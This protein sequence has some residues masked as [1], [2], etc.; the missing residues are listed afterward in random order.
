MRHRQGHLVR[1]ARLTRGAC[2]LAVAG[3]SL[4]A[5]CSLE[6]QKPTEIPPPVTPTDVREAHRVAN[7]LAVYRRDD[8]LI[9]TTRRSCSSG[10]APNLY[11]RVCGP[12]LRPL[13]A[14]QLTHLRESLDGL[15][16]RVGPDCAG[17][18]RRVA[19]V[20]SGRA[21]APLAVAARSC[22]REYLR[23]VRA[24]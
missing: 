5:G 11:E 18:L 20:S 15:R 6:E 21:G 22:R 10:L 7:A 8:R 23:A 24:G 9:R 17:A 16:R 19:A 14:Q 3:T 2:L 12:E 4:F 1:K 13:V